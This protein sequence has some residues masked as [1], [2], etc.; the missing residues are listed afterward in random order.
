M[1]ALLYLL[2]FLSGV[3]GLIYETIWSR[4]LGLFVGHSAYAQVI[5]LAIFLGGMAAGALLAGRRSAR[6]RD[7][8]VAYA[9][10]ELAVGVLG[11][12]FHDGYE[13][14]V[15]VAYGAVF[16]GLAGSAALV[17]VKWAIA[18]ALILP[19]SVLLG[20]TFPLMSAGVLRRAP[21]RPGQ[22]LALLYFSNSFG[23]ALGALLAG[24]LLVALAG[25]PGTVQVAAGLNLL[26]GAVSYLVA[27][28]A[29]DRALA[30]AEAPPLG[31]MLAGVPASAAGGAGAP[32]TARAGDP[33]LWRL[34]LAV[35]FGTA[36]A[37]LIYEIA[38]IRMLALV[39]GSATHSFELMLSAFILGLALGSLWVHRRADR[40][41]RPLRTLAAVQW[42]MGLAAV[43]TLP[44]YLASF[45]WTADLLATVQRTPAGYNVFNLARYGTALAV[46][47]PATF[48][49]GMTLP[50]LTRVLLGA[51]VGERAIG[52]VYGANT[53]GSI[54][55]AT[56]AGL[57]LLP[58]VGLKPLLLLGAALDMGLG[59]LLLA[60]VQR[61][62]ERPLYAWA[63]AA[64]AL[65]ALGTI[66][67]VTHL[68]RLTLTSGVF[69]F[70]QLPRVGDQEVLFYRDGRTATV[71]AVRTLGDST[72]YLSTNG[73]PDASLGRAWLRRFPSAARPTPLNRDESTQALLALLPL[74]YR[75]AAQSAAVI[76][77]GS[78][79]TTHF[80]LGSP[81]LER[82]VTIEIEPEM[83]RGSRVYYPAN[84]RAF[85]DARSS[86]VV[87]DAKSYF[88]AAD[89]KFDLIASEPSNPWVSGVATLFTAEFY[90]RVRRQLAR[91]GVFAQWI[92][93]YE[94]SDPLVLSVLAAVHRA[95]PS[96]AVYMVGETD[97]V[98]VASGRPEL[99]PPDWSVFRLPQIAADLALA[100]PITA[101]HLEALR[102]V[103]RTVLA[104]LLDGWSPNS[105]FFPVL[106]L[107][108]DRARFQTEYASGLMGMVGDRFDVARPLMGRRTGFGRQALAPIA[109]LP[110]TTMLALGKR[111]RDAWAGLP[112]RP[113]ESD[114][115][116]ASA[117]Y[118]LRRL[119]SML[120]SDQP[121]GDWKLW[122]RD[123]AFVEADLHGG[124][125]GVVEEGFYRAVRRY[126]DAHAA[127]ARLMDAIAFFHGLAAW[128]FAEAAD[129]GGRLVE[130][131]AAGDPWLP[132]EFLGDG[133]VVA[134]L[135]IGD[136]A[137][138]R[139]AFDLVA[140]RAPRSREDLRRLLL[141]AHL[142][143]AERQNAVRAAL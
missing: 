99:P 143:R 112:P 70:G 6:L 38:W 68:D 69:R 138:A 37:S 54:V 87:D 50:L 7:P 140:A 121:P 125:A 31:E 18:A 133:A 122:L 135:R 92:Q 26:V 36:V 100:P 1:I 46:M 96:Y 10:V 106:D 119:E 19:Q 66:A 110:R 2:F 24:F 16:P 85:D 17:P 141:A 41:A 86:F 65:A 124:T 47:L 81:L 45:D 21:R 80:L 25:L 117:V 28:Q 13:A 129:A 111:L 123:F 88:A 35:S 52:W 126:A 53:L 78:G 3:A 130:A 82:V 74:A 113:Q 34:L 89:E 136:V 72:V 114:P 12:L 131:A 23:A 104:P 57:L 39:L 56:L 27:R 84:R 90:A 107:G 83:L 55:G 51:G 22:V 108:A 9:L 67:G 49:A 102:L 14:V 44:V 132:P 48:C 33:R 63:A 42:L 95:F 109:R 128:D 32:F 30:P 93:V 120:V 116:L 137:A 134:S 8:L 115:E 11:A 64:A 103:D 77:H 58:L 5:V 142:A 29:A 73:K 40:F 61:G 118:R 98:L 139:R 43:A 20:A 94:I 59:V 97:I 15:G 79:M 75:P 76:G 105:D 71:A 91:D 60:A 127:P 101:E 62:R 4:Y